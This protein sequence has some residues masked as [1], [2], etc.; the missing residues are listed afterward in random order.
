[1]KP[2]ESKDCLG[3]LKVRYSR[4]AIFQLLCYISIADEAYARAVDLVVS[5]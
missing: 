3:F 5:N 2:T 1:M 4:N